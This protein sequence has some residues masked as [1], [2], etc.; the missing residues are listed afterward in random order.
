ML[1]VRLRRD[2]IVVALKNK[3]FIY[4]FE[5]LKQLQQLES[6]DNPLGLCALCTRRANQPHRPDPTEPAASNRRGLCVRPL[7]PA[8][9]PVLLCFESRMRRMD[10]L[11][12]TFHGNT[13]P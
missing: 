3:I 11:V 10:K 7:L 13:W 9:L 6:V 8:S 2:K 12:W 5:D 1:G 4:N